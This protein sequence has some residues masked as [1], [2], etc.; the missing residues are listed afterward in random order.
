MEPFE[1]AGLVEHEFPPLIT[2]APTAVWV[3]Y[4][5]CWRT[6]SQCN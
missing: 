1:A 6:Q 3:W 2:I 4:P 5:Q